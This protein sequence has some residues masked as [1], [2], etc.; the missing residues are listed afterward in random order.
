M[1]ASQVCTFPARTAFTLAFSL[2]TAAM[3]LCSSASRAGDDQLV[4]GPQ[5]SPQQVV[6]IVIE[7]LRDN[8]ASKNDDGIA[9]VYKFASPGNRS[10]TGP[11]ARFS[12][13]IKR[14]F[15]DMLNHSEARYDTMEITG[16]TAVQAVWLL[17]PSGKEVGYAF[18]VSKQK[19]G[20]YSDMWMTDAVVPLG[21]GSQGGTR[22]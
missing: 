14:G 5:Y 11:L 22:I 15:P 13:M 19:G 20:D 6:K 2:L 9:T 8:D 4:P 17:T 21:P 18:Q 16:D 7:A 12:N 3:I 1:H 10:S